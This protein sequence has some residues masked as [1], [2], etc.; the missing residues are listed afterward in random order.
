MALTQAEAD[1]LL[2]M[3]KI[4]RSPSAMT[5]A[6]SPR[7]FW[8]ATTTPTGRLDFHR[9]SARFARTLRSGPLRLR[10]EGPAR[11][12]ALEIRV[13]PEAPHPRPRARAQRHPPLDRA[14]D[15]PPPGRGAHPRARLPA[16]L[17]RRRAPGPGAPAA[18]APV[19]NRGERLRHLDVAG[20]GRRMKREAPSWSSLST[21]SSAKVLTDLTHARG[22]ARPRDARLAGGA[23]GRLRAE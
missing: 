16:P 13:Q 3:A 8:T 19:V 2:G 14:A 18:V 10:A 4:F 17:R 22:P 1:A 11:G 12:H 9:R 7:R 15:D 6:R 23:T 21:P 5:S 20:R